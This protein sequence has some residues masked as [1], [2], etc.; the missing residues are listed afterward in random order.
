MRQY[1]SLDYCL[2]NRTKQGGKGYKVVCPSCGG[3]DLW[4]TTSNQRG[5]CFECTAFYFIGEENDK[6]ESARVRQQFDIPEIRKTYSEALQFYRSALTK[7]HKL[8]LAKR[9]GSTE[10]E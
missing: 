6:T 8:Y 5:Y 9:F 4:I 1:L 2:Q 10:S 3:K 7:E